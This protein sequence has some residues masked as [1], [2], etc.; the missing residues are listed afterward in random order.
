MK[1]SLPLR[2]ERK[3]RSKYAKNVGW[4]ADFPD[5][6]WQ[7]VVDLLLQEEGEEEE[8]LWEKEA[9]PSILHLP[10]LINLVGTSHRITRILKK[11]ILSLFSRFLAYFDNHMYSNVP[12]RG[13]DMF[14]SK[15][16]WFFK[17]AL[18]SINLASYVRI[19]VGQES[20]QTASHFSNALSLF[21]LAVLETYHF[22]HYG[23]GIYF[24]FYYR[25]LPVLGDQHENQRTG[26]VVCYV[27][28]K[29]KACYVPRMKEVVT[30]VDFCVRGGAI[31][32]TSL[33][34]TVV[35]HLCKSIND[36][37]FEAFHGLAA[38]SNEA[39]TMMIDLIQEEEGS[40]ASIKTRRPRA[41]DPFN[42]LLVLGEDNKWHY[43]YSEAC[44]AFRSLCFCP[45]RGT[46]VSSAT[47]AYFLDARH[48]RNWAIVTTTNRYTIVDESLV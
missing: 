41:N 18:P 24:D 33:Y 6:I 27:K 37:R 38:S 45:R 46:S 28:E 25:P 17:A 36:P 16:Y 1:R 11:H 29:K 32:Q 47:T 26:D 15:I 22:Y 40:I 4:V 19:I 12:Y 3:R 14:Y 9:D 48:E 7:I 31:T 30:C 5:D 39:K 43:V 34:A 2:K 42:T 44:Q 13:H 35:Q 21:N 20:Y 10:L 8:V 23:T